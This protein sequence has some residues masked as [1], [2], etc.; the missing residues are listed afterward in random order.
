MQSEKPQAADGQNPLEA[1]WRRAPVFRRLVYAAGVTSVA[2]VLAFSLNRPTADSRVVAG[3]NHVMTAN[4]GQPLLNSPK[5]IPV[6]KETEIGSGSALVTQKPLGD[7]AQD[8]SVANSEEESKLARCHPHLLPGMGSMPQIDV[9]Q[10]ADPSVGHLK[11]HF[12]VNGAGFVTRE[13]LTA[14]TY[15][16][17]AEQQAEMMYTNGLTFSVPNTAECRIR[18]VELIGDYFEMKSRSGGWATYVKLYPRLSFDA[19]GGLIR[20]D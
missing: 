20:R 9:S 11:V 7:A 8:A 14:S 6:A 3:S 12:W 13:V 1:L 4:Q 16:T 2:G 15:G 5:A 17:A 19:D 10:I 18:E